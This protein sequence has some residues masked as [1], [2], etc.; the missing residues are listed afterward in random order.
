M[1]ITDRLRKAF[2]DCT[3]MAGVEPDFECVYI[4]KAAALT[5]LDDIDAAFAAGH[6]RAVEYGKSLGPGTCRQEE[7]GW[8][9]EGDHARV[10]LTCGH[11][12][13]VETV[14]DL[15][16]FCPVCGARVEADEWP[17]TDAEPMPS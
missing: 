17:A 4:V 3:V 1:S 8:T 6:D 14:A 2:D 9:T 7:R 16:N 10:F 5:I 15:P 13:M 11:D 12:C